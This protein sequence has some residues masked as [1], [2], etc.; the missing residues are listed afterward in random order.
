ML[1]KFARNPDAFDRVFF[2]RIRPKIDSYD[3]LA[4]I[5]KRQNAIYKGFL[6]FIGYAHGGLVDWRNG[7]RL[8]FNSDVDDHHIFPKKYLSNSSTEDDAEITDSILN[9]ALIPKL[10]NIKIGGQRPSA[11][12][13]QLTKSNPNLQSALDNH[14]IPA[15]IVQ[16]TFDE[17]YLG[18]LQARGNAFADVF[19]AHLLDL[20]KQLFGTA[21]NTTDAASPIG[22]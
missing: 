5:N 21:L 9:R 8:S 22:C 6:N 15:G 12:L 4:A 1:S 17:N 11:Y 20:E 18:F 2:K 7:D 10:T 14:L 16:G 19:N 13:G 3:D